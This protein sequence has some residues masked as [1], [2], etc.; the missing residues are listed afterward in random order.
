[1][2]P[3]FRLGFGMQAI[4]ATAT[5]LFAILPTA[6]VGAVTHVR[7]KTCQVPLGIVLGLGG[8]LTSPLGVLLASISPSWLVMTV[9]SI[10]ITYSAIS[11]FLKAY[12]LKSSKTKEE[13]PDDTQESGEEAP[14]RLTRKRVIIAVCSGL[15]A[16]FISGYIGVGGGFIMVPIM[17]GVMGFPMKQ[18]SGT[19]L[20]AMSILVI[21]GVIQQSLLG[22]IQ[23]M[24][25]LA[26]ALGSVP[27]VM[28]G[29]R[30]V[31]RVPERALR[32]I[33]SAFLVTA[34]LS[35]ALNEFSLLG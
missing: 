8:A 33:F 20:L 3:V 1:M 17:V 16:G 2:L 34:A 4:A 31:R 32:F 23:Y 28:V 30:L 19:S 27:G 18:A 5:S 14:W 13:L 10:V 12:R 11:M 35:L 25:G 7:Q 6:L 9:A 26:V 29:A 15:I 21:P 24:V 22:N